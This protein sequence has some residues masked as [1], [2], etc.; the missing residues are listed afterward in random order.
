VRER[1][2]LIGARRETNSE[3]NRRIN[4]RDFRCVGL[5]LS[6]TWGRRLA[7]ML[8]SSIGPTCQSGKEKEGVPVRDGGENGP[9][10]A[11]AAGLKRFPGPFN[12]F[13]SK[14][15]FLFLFYLKSFANRL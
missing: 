3:Q 11:S 10:A 2:D 15:F 7:S 8:A 13:L 12:V 14:P 4:S 9:R 5:I 1:G 6:E